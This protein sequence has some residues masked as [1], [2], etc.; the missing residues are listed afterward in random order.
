MTGNPHLQYLLKKALDV[1]TWGPFAL[2][3]PGLA[4]LAVLIRPR[5]FRA[6]ASTMGLTGGVTMALQIVLIFMFQ[7]KYGV[8]YQLIGLL[9]AMFM[10]GLAGGGLLGRLAVSGGAA[11]RLVLPLLDLLLAACAGLAALSAL[12]R[13]PDLTLPV[14]LTTGLLSGLEFALLYAL[15]R[16]DRSRPEPALV[17]ARLEAADHLGAAI[18][19]LAAGLVMAPVLGL[20]ASAIVLA[21]I[22]AAN[23][24]CLLAPMEIR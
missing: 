2:A 12:G 16:R 11:P 3:I 5:P 20:W 8:L 1:R 10:A 13:L 15:A 17:L 7:N 21:S 24:L 6:A 23:G 19:I 4:L 14:I 9:S 18:G 22:K